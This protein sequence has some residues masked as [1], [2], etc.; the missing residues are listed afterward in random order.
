MANSQETVKYTLTYNE[1]VNYSKRLFTQQDILDLDIIHEQRESVFYDLLPIG[2]TVDSS[3]VHAA[4]YTASS[5]HS[6]RNCEYTLETIENWRDTGRTM[7]KIHVTAPVNVKNFDS[8][9]TNSVLRSGFTVTFTLINT[10]QNI[11][12]YGKTV[13]NSSAYYSFD[14]ELVN[15]YADT[16]GNLTEKDL[17]TDMDGDGNPSDAQKNVTYAECTTTFNPLIAAQLRFEKSV[18]TADELRYGDSAKVSAAGTYTYQLRFA[19]DKNINTNDVVIYDILES[20][21]RN[22][23]HWKGTLKSI[24]TAQP[25]SKGIKPV[26]YYSI[27]SEFESMMENNSFKELANT[28][29]WSTTPPE[30]LAKVTAIAIDLRY[31]EDGTEYTFTPE[32]TALCYI[33]MTA[34]EDYQNYVDN[35]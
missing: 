28:A 19:N 16:G 1:Y 21:H 17:F 8:I 34:P 26:I 30:D 23:Q 3:S 29:V 7:L 9:Y 18:R 35:L 20:A 15:G 4:T 33:T 10:W 12:D 13:R 5:N 27:S 14:G 24:N 6:D 2:T 31:R 11:G 25:E 22:K 32:E